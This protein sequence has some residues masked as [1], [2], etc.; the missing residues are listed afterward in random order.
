[1]NSSRRTMVKGIA[2]VVG[3]TALASGSRTWAQGA[4]IVLKGIVPYHPQNYLAQPLFI[5]QKMLEERTRGQIRIQFVGGEEV[6]KALDQFDAVRN[7]VVDIALGIASYYNGTVPEALAVQYNQK[8]LPADMRKNGFYDLM[9]K[10]HLDKANVIYLANASGNPGR[11]FRIY[12]KKP[13]QRAD[14]SGLKIRV[15]PVY[16]AL[17]Q[18]LGGIPVSMPPADVY[19]A[20]ER[21]VV[22]GYGWTYAGILDY[23]FHEVAKYAI[24]PPF[25]SLNSAMILNRASYERMPPAARAQLEEIAKDFE[26]EVAKFYA[27]YIEDEDG[28]LKAKGVEKI[29]LPPA[30][31]QKYVDVAYRGGWA[32]FVAKNPV[33]GPRLKTLTGS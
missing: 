27:K 6:V 32:D 29:I 9:R 13:I 4:S 25:Y 21:G 19:S 23:S 24:E 31:A 10:I 8:L 17:V 20:L 5:L 28:R 15:S 14:L 7:G 22:D 33:D 16:T 1:M 30:E 18:G 11:A 26:T 12:T 2:A 3:G